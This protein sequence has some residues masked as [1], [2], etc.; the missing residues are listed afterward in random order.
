MPLMDHAATLLTIAHQI[1][2]VTHHSMSTRWCRRRC[3]GVEC[4][5]G[6]ATAV[7]ATS[8]VRGLQA[9]GVPTSVTTVPLIGLPYLKKYP[10]GILMQ[11]LLR[12]SYASAVEV[13]VALFDSIPNQARSVLTER[14]L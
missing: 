13:T 5:R 11:G 2:S 9:T 12:A 1:Q 8:V 4:P 10:E 7:S 6:V 14:I 3:S